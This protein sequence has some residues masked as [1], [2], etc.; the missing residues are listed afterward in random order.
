M[1]QDFGISSIV[2]HELYFGAFKSTQI[3][4]NLSRIERL[5][6]AIVEFDREDAREAGAIRASLSRPGT[7]IGPYDA[8]I[9]G[10]AKARG[11]T[12]VTRNTREFAR[13]D[14]LKVE[15]WEGTDVSG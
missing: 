11:L 9:A 13:V 12:L 7:P 8:L 14:G 2:V 10:Q 6:L 4:A 1:P 15:N 3:E 5:R